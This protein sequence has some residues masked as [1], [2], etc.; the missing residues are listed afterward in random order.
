MNARM[1]TLSM[2]GLTSLVSLMACSSKPV[3]KIEYYQPAYRQSPPEPVYNRMVWS[4]L[5]API[6]PKARNDA[7]L[8][9]PDVFVELKNATLDEAVEALAQT[10]GYRWEYPGVTSKSRINIHMEGDVETILGEIRKQSE[11]PLL[12]DHDRRMIRLA[13]KNTQPRL[14]LS[15]NDQG[16]SITN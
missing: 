11:V 2:L 6:R 3:Y 12:M 13:D 14:P 7:P 10:M 9:L 4:H 16:R 15:Q 8:L 5:P 1:I